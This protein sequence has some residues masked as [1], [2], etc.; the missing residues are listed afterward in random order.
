MGLLAHLRDKLELYKLEQKYTKRTKRSG[1]VSGAQYVDGEYVYS[2][3]SLPRGTAPI[4]LKASPYDSSS[5]AAGAQ[6]G[7]MEKRDSATRVKQIL[8]RQSAMF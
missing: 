7:W 3:T 5:S 6:R 8:K 4:T 1:Y 2:A